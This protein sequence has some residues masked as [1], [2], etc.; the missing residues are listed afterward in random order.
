[1]TVFA[2]RLQLV[3]LGLLLVAAPLSAS[4][5]SKR[6][7]VVIADGKGKGSFKLLGHNSLGNRGMNA[8]LAVRGDY[9]YIG[10]RTDGGAKPFENGVKVVDI[11]NPKKPQ[12]V[13]MIGRPYE[14]NEG[15]TSRE[16]R[17]WP[18]KDL[19]IVM[20]LGSNCSEL[21]HECSPRSV[22]DNIRFYDISG[23]NA[24][25]PKF[26]SE[27]KPSENPHEMFL[28][29]DPRRPGRALLFLS[30][31][32]GDRGQL[33]V[34]DISKARKDKFV[35]VAKENFIVGEQGNDNRLHSLTVSP[36]GKRAYLAYLEAGFLVADTTDFARAEK[37]P[38]VRLITPPKKAPNWAEEIG[39]GAHSAAP[40]FGSDY[41]LVTDEVYGE[42]LRPLDSGGCP[43]G[44]TRMLDVRKPQKPKVVAQ[45]KLPQN[46]PDYCTRDVP[47]PSSSY[48]AHNLTLT[49][50]LAFVTWHSAG[51][52]AIDISRPQKPAE[53]A[54]FKP[55]PPLLVQQEDPAL[56]A[57]QD[58][59]VMWSF[60]IIQD[61][62]IY[63]VDVRNGL[64]ILKY[65]GPYE[66][67]VARL[68]FLE[69]NS[70]LGAAVKLQER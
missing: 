54:S 2:K 7:N 10:S 42:A 44:W 21:I 32:G 59:V 17:I 30:T 27:Y 6:S 4:A 40:L 13:H 14:N 65:R 36:D 55:D 61:G 67:E 48:S 12:V 52:Q 49:E 9:V 18:E 70:N 29:D 33:L 16:L 5:D 3:M 31:P 69:G 68:G 56:S 53:S 64:Y 1:M 37:K 28:W 58:K 57:G 25:K 24:A 66:K 38:R 11:S 26:I 63:V 50:H 41:V 34:T 43:W 47:R 15:E 62:L 45:Y 39:P 51:L 23:K 35:E 60:P 20:N 8:A 22:D 19:L 46:D